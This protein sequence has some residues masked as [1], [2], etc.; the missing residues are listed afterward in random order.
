MPYPLVWHYDSLTPAC[1]RLAPV[2][3]A[4]DAGRGSCRASRARRGERQHAEASACYE[5]ALSL[6]REFGDRFYEAEALTHLGE[7]RHA[8]GEL[9]QAQ[10]AW[11][12]ALAVVEDLRHPGA[13]QIRARLASTGAG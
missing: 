11:Q 1:S 2:C 7:T 3:A 9:A 12:Q 4:A 10:D 13:G 6:Y 5:R 8:L